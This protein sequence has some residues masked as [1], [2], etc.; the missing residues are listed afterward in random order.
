M[1]DNLL[2]A[3]DTFYDSIGDDFDADRTVK[4]FSEA[5]NDSGFMLVHGGLSSS[6]GLIKNKISF[7][8]MPSLPIELFDRNLN[9]G[10]NFAAHFFDHLRLQTPTF[11]TSV[12]SGGN[13]RE[14]PVFQK[15]SEPWG[16]HSEVIS[17]LNKGENGG[18]FSVAVRHREQDEF[19]SDAFSAMSALN[20]HLNKAMSLQKRIERFEYEIVRA[21]DTLDLIDIGLVLYDYL[22]KPVFIN[23][24]VRVLMGE[25]DGL[26]LN[27]QGIFIQNRDVD[28]KFQEILQQLHAISDPLKARAGMALRVPRPSGKKP[29]GLMAVPLKR[30]SKHGMEK[31]SVAV[32]VFDPAMQ[33]N[34]MVK[35]FA[36]SFGLTPTEAELTYMLAQGIS[37]DEFATT[38][39][40]SRNTAKWHLQTVFGKTG[41]SRQHELVSLVLRSSV[42]ADIN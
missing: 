18:A 17:V 34:K 15:M 36:T 38:R 42:G 27:N 28:Q 33:N 23:K 26:E 12:A 21:S 20:G 29:Y 2:Q 37:I 22:G 4:A 39:G 19:D 32:F 5:I 1:S 6:S 41:T 16:L 3:I 8:N 9:S 10:D 30:Y 7:H 40:I 25:K 11:V 35:L 13:S 14:H 24:F 31:T